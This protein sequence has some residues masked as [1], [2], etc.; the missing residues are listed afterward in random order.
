MSK[1]TRYQSA[2]SRNTDEHISEDHWLKQFENTLQKGA[3]QPKSQQSLFEQINTIM[4]GTGSKYPSVQAAVD[5]MM[6]RSGLTNYLQASDQPGSKTKTAADQNEDFDKKVPIEPKQQSGYQLPKLVQENPAILHTL[7]NYI[8][9]TR[10]NL[11]IPAIIDKIRSIHRGDVADDKLWDDDDFVRLVSKLN[12]EA[13]TNNPASYENYN[14][15]A[16]SDSD[17][18]SDI[19]PSNTDAFNVLMPAK[20]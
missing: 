10:G 11:P 13:K 3:V 12:L 20:L 6:Q 9:T 19:D 17:A 2:V 8:R 16:V 14:N 4:N 7:E 5:D 18:D 15:L 1:Y